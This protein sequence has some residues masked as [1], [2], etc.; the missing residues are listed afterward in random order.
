MDEDEAL[1][2]RLQQEFDEQ[3]AAAARHQEEQDAVMARALS[4]AR[5]PT[6]FYGKTRAEDLNVD[7]MRVLI[8][9]AGL[10][11]KDCI[12]KQDLVERAKMAW[13]KMDVPQHTA[14][15][16]V[17]RRAWAPP[18]L[19]NLTP[20]DL[21]DL[22]KSAVA[23]GPLQSRLRIPFVA[24]E[25]FRVGD[26]E[27][28]MLRP[29]YTELF[30]VAYDELLDALESMQPDG[31]WVLLSALAYPFSVFAARKFNH[32]TKDSAPQ[33]SQRV[34]DTHFA[35]AVVVDRVARDKG[36]LRFCR[37]VLKDCDTVDAAVVSVAVT[38]LAS[39]ATATR[40]TK[41]VRKHVLG[42]ADPTND[43]R[44]LRELAVDVGRFLDKPLEPNAQ[45]FAIQLPVAS[46]GAIAPE[47][48]GRFDFF[49]GDPR[50]ALQF[51]EALDRVKSAYDDPFYDDLA[52]H[53]FG[54]KRETGDAWDSAKRE[55]ARTCD[56]PGCTNTGTKKCA[57][58]K[59][60]AYCSKECQNLDWPQHKLICKRKSSS[61]KKACTPVTPPTR[62]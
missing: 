20:L 42:D 37:R 12:E 30:N 51:R 36:I 54:T 18:H 46:L 2:R 39:A 43:V 19:V 44:N 55:T 29:L 17:P 31:T 52:D 50:A 10:D 38:I 15:F 56:R 7:E 35:L 21:L 23:A 45:L 8:L 22:A 28:A 27:L 47:L 16:Y 58:C 5:P 53:V 14:A 32:T 33:L 25:P 4:S 26:D 57:G 60:V 24:A 41:I 1:A 34:Y 62:V 49:Q 11:F 59:I 13:A 40:P 48:V 3:E 61:K 6:T 9:E